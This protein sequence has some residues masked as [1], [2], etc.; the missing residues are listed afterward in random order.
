M[1]RGARVTRGDQSPLP[2]PLELNHRILDYVCPLILF[3]CCTKK[4][5]CPLRKRKAAGSTPG[6]VDRYSGCEN[7]RHAC[8]TIMGHVNDPLSINL[9]LILSQN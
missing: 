8:H 4:V 7:H 9:A 5:E 2:I 6:G 1:G 3:G